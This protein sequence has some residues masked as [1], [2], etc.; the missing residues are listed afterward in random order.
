LLIKLYMQ[1]KGCFPTKTT[2]GPAG[3]GGNDHTMSIILLK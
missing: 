1:Q 2:E 3:C